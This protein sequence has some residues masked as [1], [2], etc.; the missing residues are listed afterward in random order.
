VEDP[1]DGYP[2]PVLEE[3]MGERC[4]PT[5]A[6]YTRVE[7][8]VRGDL[9]RRWVEEQVRSMIVRSQ[10]VVLK[11]LFAD[12]GFPRYLGVIDASSDTSSSRRRK[13]KSSR[14]DWCTTTAKLAS[15]LRKLSILRVM[16]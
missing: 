15:T 12:D 2:R 5:G 16:G 10:E 3:R 8:Y 11:V 14:L 6:I 4:S 1:Y 13:V 7:G 9:G